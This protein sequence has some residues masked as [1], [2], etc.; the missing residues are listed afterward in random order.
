MPYWNSINPKTV[1]DVFNAPQVSLVEMENEFGEEWLHALMVKWMNQ[2]LRFYSMN[3]TMD[4]IQVGD[5]I[6]L[7]MEEYPHYV[8]DDFKLFF[9]MAKKGMFGQVYGRM[10]GEVIMRWLRSYD[11][12]RDTAAQTE[13]IVE[14]QQY[15]DENSIIPD[16]AGMYFSEY[17]TMLQKKAQ[18][19]DTNAALQIKDSFLN[20]LHTAMPVKTNNKKKNNG[21]RY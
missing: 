17:I 11:I 8:Q 4:A 16:G 19:G 18:G 6:V 13:S 7:M 14:S 10:D 21:K 9:K 2:F 20:S 15:K 1:I 5:T 12:H 3:A